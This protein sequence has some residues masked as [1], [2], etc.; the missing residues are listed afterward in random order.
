M[1]EC[2]NAETPQ[3]GM[4]MLKVNQ[5]EREK[6]CDRACCTVPMDHAHYAFK[7]ELDQGPGADVINEF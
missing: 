1:E 4:F 3:I 7:A 6:L 2:T 5:R